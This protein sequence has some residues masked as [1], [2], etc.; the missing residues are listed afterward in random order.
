VPQTDDDVEA[1]Y[2]RWMLSLTVRQDQHPK[3]QEESSK[4]A[5]LSFSL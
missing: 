5:L 2:L 3:R 4:L 1:L